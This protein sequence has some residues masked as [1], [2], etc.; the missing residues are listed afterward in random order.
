M[1]LEVQ[2]KKTQYT[3][4]EVK[5]IASPIPVS[6]GLAIMGRRVITRVMSR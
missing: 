3:G 6:T 4:T 2:A 5:I 1:G